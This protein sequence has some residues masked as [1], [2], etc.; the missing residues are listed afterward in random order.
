MV[1]SLYRTYDRSPVLEDKAAGFFPPIRLY[2]LLGFRSLF[3]YS[4]SILIVSSGL[5]C[6][7]VAECLPGIPKVLGSFPVP[8]EAE[9]S[10]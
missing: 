1:I 9:T 5:E 3:V 4:V 10:P 8:R 2:L 6:S 7:L